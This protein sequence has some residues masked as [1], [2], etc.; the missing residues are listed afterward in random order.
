MS[1]ILASKKQWFATAAAIVMFSAH[2]ALAQTP[3]DVPWD[4]QTT[5]AEMQATIDQALIS[6]RIP[7][8]TVSIRQGDVRWVSNSGVADVA[9]GAAPTPDTTFAYRSVTKSFVTTVVLQLAEEGLV[10]LDDPVGKYVSGVPGGDEVTIRQLAEMRSGLFNYTSSPEF[11]D[12]LLTD[13][14]RAWTGQELLSFAFVE[15]L[16]FTPGTSYEYSNTNTVLLG[17]VISAATGND[18]ATEVKR[19]ISSQ[20]GLGSV[21]NQGAGEMPTPNAVGYVDFDDGEGPVSFAEFNASGAGASG[22]LVGVLEDLERW[23]AALGSGELIDK[24]DY[25]ERLKS[26]GSTAADPRSPEYDSYGFGMGE[27]SGYI[28]HTGNGLGFEALVMYDRANDRTITIL[29][30]ASNPGDSNAPADLF[31]ELLD[32]LSWTG[33]D[34]QIQVAADGRSETVGSGTVWTGLVSGPFLTRAAVYADNGGSATADGRVTLAPIQ[35]YVPA[36]YVGDGRVELGLGGEITASVGGDGAF[37]KTTTGTASLSLNDVSI[38]LSGDEISGIGIDARDN[39]VAALDGVTI[40]GTALAGLHAGGDASATIRGTGVDIALSRGDGV[41]VEANG[42]IDL[43]DSR[44][45]LSGPG[46]GL[47]VSGVNGAAQMRG[48]DLTVETSAPGSFGVLAYG[49]GADVAL[50]GGSV[51]TEGAGAHAIAMGHGAQIGL[52]GVAV[53]AFGAS[54]AAVAAFAMDD[55][56][57]S[58]SAAILLENSVVSAA[59]GTA[60]VA[61]GTDL[62]LTASGSAIVG[63]VTRS[64]DAR[65]DLSLTN[66][67]AWTLAAAGSGVSSRVDDLMNAGSTIA[68]APPAG[69]GFHSL[70]VGNYSAANGTL[71]MN[72]E[73]SAG[74]AADR[75]VIDGGMASGR[76][77]VLI[78]PIGDGGLTTGDGIKLIETANGGQTTPGAFMLENRVASGALEYALYRG[79]AAGEDDWF[80]RSTQD[81][82]TG[83]DALANLRPEVAVD[84]ALPAIA[85]QYG[86]AILGTRE[87]RVA[88]RGPGDQS[89]FWGRA[90]GET[91]TKGSSGGDAAS[92]LDRFRSDGPSYDVDLGGFQVGYDFALTEPG[93][94]VQNLVGFYVGAGQ[95]RGNVDA[96]YGGAAGEVSMDAYSLGAYWNQSRASGL[97]IDA[98]LQGT[99]YDQAKTSS[100]PG[101]TFKT[102]GYG[103]IGSLEAGYRFDLGQGWAIEPQAQLVYQ[104]LSFDDGADSYGRVTYDASND[105]FGRIGGKLSRGWTLENGQEMTAFA[106]ANLWHGFSDG[107][108]VTFAGLGGGNAMSF[109][110]GLEGTRAQLGLGASMAVSET[111][112]LFA[113]GDYET[114]LDDMSGHGFGGRIG[115]TVRW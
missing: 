82:A 71:D 8:A 96:V 78:S 53:T 9:T 80:L 52:D 107:P 15:P 79:S 101:Q 72:A 18:W 60:V 74:G 112:S 38:L 87:E 5:A 26:F 99:F 85:S 54:A 49:N 62:T 21:V 17:E 86:L 29:L 77:R 93:E 68:F 97:Q 19:R 106:R 57:G 34:N 50:A 65:I 105:V 41:W 113:S 88:V 91:G 83:P 92:Q 37:L 46:M 30:N 63:A 3:G 23:G 16:E 42:T 45:A 109:D 59:S 12:E 110:T 4:N 114:R 27:I 47:H 111:V 10:G 81:G 66:G 95:A 76:T 100:V 6:K 1:W 55:V 35:D 67:S 36:I 7:G 39:A 75:L 115:A 40:K 64:S 73:L 24:R 14:G 70:I 90:F 2:G 51:V 102:D 56:P 58:R 103:L 13:P 108:E 22:A 25:V 20:L 98:V 89:A 69:A 31:R 44:I 84:T 61:Q 94:A 33:P 48:V 11:V 32:V 43:N 28:G 104:R